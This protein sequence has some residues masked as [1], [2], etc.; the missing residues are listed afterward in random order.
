MLYHNPLFRMHFCYILFLLLITFDFSSFYSVWMMFVLDSLSLL[1]NIQGQTHYNNLI[2]SYRIILFINVIIMS[3]SFLIGC[4][5]D[6]NTG[7]V[8]HKL[9]LYNM[10]FLL[11]RIVRFASSIIS[12]PWNLLF[13]GGIYKSKKACRKHCSTSSGV[14]NLFVNLYIFCG[15]GKHFLIKPS[16]YCISLYMLL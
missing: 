5:M 10:P 8:N 6:D 15:I 13:C 1:L 16:I 3:T 12:W 4:F 14:C 11:S 2:G 9:C 7:I